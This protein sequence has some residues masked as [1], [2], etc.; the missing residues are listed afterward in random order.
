MQ[1]VHGCKI[2]MRGC[3]RIQIP[4][5]FASALSFRFGP[6]LQLTRDS[7]FFN[8]LQRFSQALYPIDHDM[9]PPGAIQ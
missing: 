7:F 1:S 9:R 6:V 4:G 5:Q 2:Y 8:N 3:V